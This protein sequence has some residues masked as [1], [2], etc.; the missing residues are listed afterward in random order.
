[1]FLPTVSGYKSFLFL[2]LY[3]IVFIFQINFF[4]RKMGQNR[5]GAIRTSGCADH[6]DLYPRIEQGRAQGA[7][8]CGQNQ[9]IS[10]NRK[11]PIA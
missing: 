7:K 1:M 4:M 3:F 2:K 6:N 8:S 9:V 5:S 11:K 10:K